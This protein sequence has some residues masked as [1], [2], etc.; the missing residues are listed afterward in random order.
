MKHESSKRND[1]DDAGAETIGAGAGA[2]IG[3]GVTIGVGVAVAAAVAVDDGPLNNFENAE[4]NFVGCLPV[5]AA[6]AAAGT[7]ATDVGDGTTTG[8][9]I[10]GDV[11][12]DDDIEGNEVDAFVATT[13]FDDV[14][15]VKSKPDKNASKDGFDVG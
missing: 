7:G 4:N 10:V 12:D 6:T 5:G 8:S 9:T 13:G 11:D 15:D 2:E 1:D 3:A 14:G